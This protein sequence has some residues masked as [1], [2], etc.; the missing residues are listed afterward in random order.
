MNHSV[1][2]SDFCDKVSKSLPV[3]RKFCPL[4]LIFANSLD[5]Y[6]AQQTVGP[7]LDPN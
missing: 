7:D 6:Q 4:L 2:P 1:F 3:S 5:P